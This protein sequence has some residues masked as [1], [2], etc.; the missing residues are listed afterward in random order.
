MWV[1]TLVDRW[2]RTHNYLG[3]RV[4]HVLKMVVRGQTWSDE[5]VEALLDVWSNGIIQ[6]QLYWG[7]TGMILS[8]AGLW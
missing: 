6:A 7:H 4:A 3:I 1:P 8:I 5:A 2:F